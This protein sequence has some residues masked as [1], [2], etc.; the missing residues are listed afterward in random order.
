MGY[1]VRIVKIQALTVDYAIGL[2]PA[3]AK[4]LV[5]IVGTRNPSR[6]KL[7]SAVPID[8]IPVAAMAKEVGQTDLNQ[9][10]TYT[11]PSFQSSRQT[12]SDGTDH[13]D[14]QLRGLGSDQSWCL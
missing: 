14:H 13:Q 7:Q 10:L 11:A 9:L 4:D 1:E 2:Q 12:V 8:L 5:T 3:A 6:T